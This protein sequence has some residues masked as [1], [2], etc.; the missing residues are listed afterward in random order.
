M[1]TAKSK[2]D[3]LLDELEADLPGLVEQSATPGDFWSEFIAGVDSIGRLSN[4]EGEHVAAR[5]DR[6]LAPYGR[7]I[8]TIHM[9]RL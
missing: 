2:L 9:D 4:E 6:M 3:R 7:H 1:T 8:I 5:I